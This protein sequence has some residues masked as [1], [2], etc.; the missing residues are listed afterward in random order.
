[1]RWR[2]KN[3]KNEGSEG[4]ETRE[5]ERRKGIWMDKERES[6]REGSAETPGVATPVP[7]MS[8]KYYHP[9]RLSLLR[10]GSTHL[11]LFISFHP[12]FVRSPRHLPICLAKKDRGGREESPLPLVVTAFCKYLSACFLLLFLLKSFKSFLDLSWSCFNFLSY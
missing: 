8:K 9:F 7:T 11:F 3:E 4:G 6:A 10:F 2:E 1:M 12:F 5:D